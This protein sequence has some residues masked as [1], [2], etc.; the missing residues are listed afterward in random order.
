MYA[1]AISS[2]ESM[3][4]GRDPERERADSAQERAGERD[5]RVPPGS[6]GASFIA[7]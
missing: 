6:S 4:L 5:A 1:S 2:R 7:T 3:R